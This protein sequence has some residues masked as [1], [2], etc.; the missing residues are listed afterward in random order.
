MRRK[1]EKETEYTDLAPIDDIRNGDEYLN[2]LD[3]ALTNKRVKN[4]ALAGPYGAGKSSVIETYLKKHKKIKRKSLRISMATFIENETDES[5]NLKKIQI[6]RNEIEI[7]I[8]KQLFYKVSYKIIPQSRYR[9]LHKIGWK[10][11]WGW[12][13]VLSSVLASLEYIF[14]PDRFYGTITKIKTAGS[15]LG[16]KDF[17]SVGLFCLFFLVMLA[18]L[19]KGYRSVLSKFKVNEVKL[20]TD[21]TLK[22]D[23]ESQETIFNKNMDEIVYFF[24]ETKYRIVFFEDLDRLEDSSIFIQLRE[25]NTLLNNYDV[26]KEPIIFVYAVKD[27]IFTDTDRT[28]FFDFII[29]VIPIIN[30][31]NSGEILLEKLKESK[32][33]GITHEIS[34]GYVLDVSPYISDMRILQNIYNE[35]VVYKKTLRTEQDL[36]LSDETMMSLI[37]FKNLYPKDFADIQM[38]TGIIKQAF[39]D[40]NEYVMHQC[41]VWQ[42]EIDNSTE[43]LSKYDR[44]V[45]KNIK[46]LKYSMVGAMHGW[47]NTVESIEENYLHRY[48]FSEI[49][50]DDFDLSKLSSWARCT[51][52]YGSGYSSNETRIDNFQDFFTLY[53]ERWK[54]FKIIQEK[55]LAQIKLDI[56]NLKKEIHEICSWSLETLIDKFGSDKVLSAEVRNNKVLVF[57]L[58]RGYIDEKYANYIN[59]FKGNSITKDDMNFILSVKNMEPLSFRYKLTK[60]AMVV[61][62]MQVYE[63]EQKAIYNFDLLEYM[64]D[65]DEDDAK[66]KAFITQLSD[67]SKE[68]WN[69]INEFI[70]VTQHKGMFVKLLSSAWGG[71]WNHIVDDEVLTYERKICYLS[72]L[73]SE[74]AMESLIILNADGKIKDFIEDNS[75]ILQRLSSVQNDKVIAVIESLEVVFK[76]LLIQNV[77]EEVLDY[78]FDNN[79]YELNSCMI[80]RLVEFKDRNLVPNLASQNYATI[81]SLGYA[82]LLDYVHAHISSYV[83]SIVLAENNVNEAVE[84]IVELLKRNIQDTNICLRLINHENFCVDNITEC[85]GNLLDTEKQA[86]KI[87]WD[88]L[89][90]EDKVCLTWENIDAYWE[91]YGFNQEIMGYV[92]KHVDELISMDSECMS[93]AFMREFILSEIDERVYEK[94]LPQLRQNNFD[95]ELESISENRVLAMIKC[96]YFAFEAERYEELKTAYPDL[97][98][99]FILNNQNEYM[100]IMNDIEMSTELFEG[101]LFSQQLE[102]EKA[103]ILFNTYGAEHMTSK[104]AENMQ[105]FNFTVDINIFNAAWKCLDEY[106]KQNFMLGHLELLNASEF[107]ACFAELSKWYSGF[108]D[109]SKRHDVELEYTTENQKLAERLKAV[110]YITSYSSKE[111]TE[112]DSITGIGKK[113]NVLSCKVKA[114]K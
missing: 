1:N 94:L 23:D 98:L 24:E 11:I 32:K 112:F 38:E 88:E 103:Q 34:Q 49:M 82:P 15:N 6:E 3:W 89:L 91:N 41:A 61:Q 73:I 87:L 69:F 77:S 20:P 68:S 96:K 58:R 57:M 47:S 22:N 19:A 18:I 39:V 36:K 78:I 44:D 100:V 52:R 26:I 99:K 53:Y 92:E 12:L 9:K 95:M 33:L 50:R 65:G 93:D 10:H 4:I 74:T 35:F 13:I 114:I 46:E 105:G 66:L 55:G 42:E 85:C 83:E 106:G 108:K 5:G 27:D 101:L 48:S 28:K 102:Q 64:L 75:D 60:T 84:Q 113:K 72:L 30:S 109:R 79:C 51:I 71:L 14:L 67:G 54:N 25:L 45:L 56:G 21:T 90:E 63:F 16:L 86:V 81:V 29:P 107:E 59:Y 111:K 43:V 37:I 7:G 70:D 2:A 31:T 97:C 40:K 62:R 8:L 76:N 104:I 17:S 110:E 80:Q